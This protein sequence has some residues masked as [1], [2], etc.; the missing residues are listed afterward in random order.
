MRPNGWKITKRERGE[1]AGAAGGG[2]GGRQQRPPPA[3]GRRHRHSTKGKKTKSDRCPDARPPTRGGSGTHATSRCVDAPAPPHARRRRAGLGQRRRAARREPRAA[4]AQPPT[5]KKKK[6][7]D[8]GVAHAKGRWWVGRGVTQ[9]RPGGAAG[10]HGSRCASVSTGNDDRSG[11]VARVP[12]L[13]APGAGCRWGASASRTNKEPPRTATR[14]AR[15]P[16]APLG[17]SASVPLRR[18]ARGCCQRGRTSPPWAV[19]GSAP[20]GGEEVDQSAGSQRR[21][22]AASHQD[23]AHACPSVGLC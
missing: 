19:S 23:R 4:A 20:N 1:D 21:V 17:L 22:I 10:Q 7:R 5:Q 15:P 13:A 6:T 8:S 16:A 12:R 2:S 18:T 3:A 9:P 11:V 14:L